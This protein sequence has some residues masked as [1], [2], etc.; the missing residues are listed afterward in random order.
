M[1]A[2]KHV[3]QNS[4]WKSENLVCV[5]WRDACT[6]SSSR[7]VQGPDVEI[8]VGVCAPKWSLNVMNSWGNSPFLI[9]TYHDLGITGFMGKNGLGISWILTP[10]R[11]RVSFWW[12]HDLHLHW[13]KRWTVR[14]CKE[15][16]QLGLPFC[17]LWVLACFDRLNQACSFFGWSCR[18]MFIQDV[19]MFVDGSICLP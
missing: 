13:H 17:S 14:E 3:P 7:S 8:C 11:Y 19:R 15:E 16:K 5:R 2:K 12:Q 10:Y 6:I 18:C 1:I 9:G 4:T